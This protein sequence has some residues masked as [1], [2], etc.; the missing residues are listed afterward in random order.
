MLG[1]NCPL[2]KVWSLYQCFDKSLGIYPS[3]VHQTLQQ[4]WL[5]SSRYHDVTELELLLIWELREMEE[6]NPGTYGKSVATRACST[7]YLSK[8]TTLA[9]IHDIVLDLLQL[10]CT[11][12]ILILYI[13]CWLLDPRWENTVPISSSYSFSNG[14]TLQWWLRQETKGAARLYTQ[15]PSFS[16]TKLQMIRWL[17]GG[18]VG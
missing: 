1:V 14:D 2:C 3:L 13:W 16:S 12:E 4:C 18:L 10:S 15:D 5:S 11:S 9:S 17:S 8:V 7:V 6:M